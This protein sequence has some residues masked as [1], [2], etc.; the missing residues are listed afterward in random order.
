M[1]Y[2]NILVTIGPA[3]G[4]CLLSTPIINGLREAYPAANIDTIAQIARTA[5]GLSIG[6]QIIKSYCPH[7]NHA[8]EIEENSN[9]ILKAKAIVQLIMNN[10]DLI[11]DIW[12]NTRKKTF[13]SK[14]I[15]RGT[16]AG[17]DSSY[18]IYVQPEDKHKVDMEHELLEKITGKKSKL[19]YPKFIDSKKKQNIVT[20][21]VSRDDDPLRSWP[22]ERWSEIINRIHKKYKVDVLLIGADVNKERLLN[23]ARGVTDVN[24]LKASMN[25]LGLIQKIISESKLH[26]TENGGIAHLATTTHT[27]II[28]VSQSP[29]GWSPYG[30]QNIEIRKCF[31]EDIGVEEVWELI[32]KKLK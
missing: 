27:P 7:V 19:I 12:P 30:K 25:Q 21:S 18:E 29:A 14:L 23:I 24:R 17:F 16:V 1:E 9:V 31:M 6:Y 22:I 11:V 10:Y 4:D 26:L 20:L 3:I 13:F 5:P 15:S 2:K 28:S 32:R 8:I